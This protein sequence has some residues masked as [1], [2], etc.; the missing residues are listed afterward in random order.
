MQS[1]KHYF[2][3]ARPKQDQPINIILLGDPAAGKATQAALLLKK[4]RLYDL[5]MG[6]ELRKLKSTNPRIRRALKATYD[7]GNLTQTRLVRQIHKEKIFST[8]QSRGILFDGTPKMLG[9]AKLIYKWLKLQRRREPLV[10]Y[11]S[12]PMSETAK[13]MKNRVE[14]FRG[15][16]SKRADDTGAALKNRVKYYRKNITQV[17]RFFKKHYRFKKVSGLGSIV[18]VHRSL[19]KAIKHFLNEELR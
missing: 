18:Q 7:K 1:E 10:I 15:K 14:Y 2:M 3:T 6:K 8:P 4:Y 17:V 19:L 12:L 11:L 9:E 16:Y 13:R 5:D